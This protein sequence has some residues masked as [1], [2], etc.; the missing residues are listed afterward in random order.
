VVDASQ[1]LQLTSGLLSLVSAWTRL[2]SFT[3]PKNR[4]FGLKI[5]F[6]GR[7]CQAKIPVKENRTQIQNSNKKLRIPS[8]HH[9][10]WRLL[11]AKSIAAQ[12]LP[13]RSQFAAKLADKS[14]NHVLM[15]R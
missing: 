14:F 1:A 7:V 2:V 9:P 13:D 3:I 8:R 12:E 11:Q 10:G 6:L 15:F 4:L 5:T